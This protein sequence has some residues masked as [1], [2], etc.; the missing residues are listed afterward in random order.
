MSQR[1]GYLP[2]IPT[3]PNI[4]RELGFNIV[5]VVIIVFVVAGVVVIVVFIVV[6]K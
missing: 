1:N 2:Q 5:V 3:G 6:L 4:L